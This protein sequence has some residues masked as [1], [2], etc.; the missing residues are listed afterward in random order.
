MSAKNDYFDKRAVSI[1]GYGSLVPY[2]GPLTYDPAVK[3]TSNIIRLPIADGWASP[4]EI[5]RF[6]DDVETHLNAETAPGQLFY[7][8]QCK[9]FGFH[10]SGREQLTED[11]N[12]AFELA[13]ELKGTLESRYERE[14][15]MHRPCF[16]II[17]PL[18]RGLLF[19]LLRGG[20]SS[21]DDSKGEY[22]ILF[23]WRAGVLLDSPVVSWPNVEAVIDTDNGGPI[24]Q[25]ETN[26]ASVS[27]GS[28]EQDL[29]EVYPLDQETTG[30]ADIIAA[31]N[32]FAD[33]GMRTEAEDIDEAIANT[34]QLTFRINGGTIGFEKEARFTTKSM[35]VYSPEEFSFWGFPISFCT[36]MCSAH[37]SR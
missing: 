28:R 23:D 9:E 13:E 2:H 8:L 35:S 34:Q 10:S 27:V 31:R 15:M 21:S 37:R 3:G 19:V 16:V 18:E 26:V 29:Q 6:L 7:S 36:P 22:E 11:L 4:E 5:L 25:E 1:G 30:D 20:K 12:T 17:A 32:P 33:S 24:T 14:L